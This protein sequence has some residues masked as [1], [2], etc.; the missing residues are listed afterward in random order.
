MSA[1]PETPAKL[2][3]KMAARGGAT[4]EDDVA[5]AKFAELY[6]PVMRAYF[7]SENGVSPVEADDLVQDLFVRLV[8][9]IRTGG[10][11]PAKSR[12]R[13]FLVSL[14]RHILI[15][16]HRRRQ[17]DRAD[18]QD[19]LSD[20]VKADPQPDAAAMVDIRW[21]MSVRSAVIEHV[22][23]RTA[24]SVLHRNIYRE[25]VLEGVSAKDVAARY[26]VTEALVRQVKVRIGRMISALEREYTD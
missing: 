26:G 16:R 23:T 7:L 6:T 9:V 14:I 13:T 11:D 21:R 24:I 5:W 15:D 2:L 3:E 10:Y 22:F 1:F 17:A 25:Y 4:C 18:L 19:E 20:D 8:N 12:F